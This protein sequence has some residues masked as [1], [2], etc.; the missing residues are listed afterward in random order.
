MLV[1]GMNVF[2]PFAFI[3]RKVSGI[4]STV[5]YTTDPAWDWLIGFAL[6]ERTW[7]ALLKE[8]FYRR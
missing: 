1:F 4:S 2:P 6:D 3:L 8:I 7:L 5:Q